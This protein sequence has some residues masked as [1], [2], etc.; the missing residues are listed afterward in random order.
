MPVLLQKADQVC[1][2]L[3]SYLY[4]YPLTWSGKST[5]LNQEGL[6]PFAANPWERHGFSV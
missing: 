6:R 5:R 1:P 4:T 3:S 2:D